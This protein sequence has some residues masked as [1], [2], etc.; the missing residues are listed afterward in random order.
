MRAHLLNAFPLSVPADHAP[1]MVKLLIQSPTSNLLHG[2]IAR[3]LIDQRQCHRVYFAAPLILIKAVL[4][5]HPMI[6]SPR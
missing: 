2:V 6:A 1:I 5:A 3:R 4:R